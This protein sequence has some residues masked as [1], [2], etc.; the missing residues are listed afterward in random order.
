MVLNPED[1][2]LSKQELFGEIKGNKFVVHKLPIHVIRVFQ[3]FGCGEDRLK[4]MH[5]QGVRY[6]I[7]LFHPNREETEC[8][9]IK[10][11][12]WIEGIPWEN[13][14]GNGRTEHQRLIPIDQCEKN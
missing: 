13:K 11:T 12:E 6:G 10:I 4:G 3:A 14:L 7:I 8:Y 1:V 5:R 9:T 2:G